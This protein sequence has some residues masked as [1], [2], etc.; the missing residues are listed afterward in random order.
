MARD[1]KTRF[2]EV[3][4]AAIADLLEHGF[5]SQYRVNDWIRRL[6]AAARAALV[7]PEVIERALKD[8]LMRVY[9]RTVD[10]GKLAKMHADLSAFTL[11]KIKPKLRD[12][13]DR[14][15]LASASLIKLNREA[16]IQRTLQR[17]AGWATSIP[18]GGTEAEKRSEAAKQVRR[19][20]SG[21]PFEERRVVIDQGHK[22]VSAINDIVARDGGA[23]AAVWHSHWREA[24][25]DYRE[26]HKQRD[27]HLYVVRN[28]W[29]LEGGLMKLAG[30]K[31]SDEISEPGYEVYCR[32]YYQ[33]VYNL[34]DLPV[35]MLT[36]RGKAALAQ[37]REQLAG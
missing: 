17:F 14:R 1:D 26:E 21:L 16:S 33:F 37:A 5:D 35:I 3:L 8:T 28:N 15:I 34:R 32:C 23:I 7:P 22:L 4:T 30:A 11:A 6:E 24:G 19:G 29:A 9:Q 20:I 36:N 25:Y 27:R 31:Y 2:Y 13:L 12:E 18:I 10:G